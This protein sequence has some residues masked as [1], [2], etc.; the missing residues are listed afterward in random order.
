[1]IG[2]L[3]EANAAAL[4]KWVWSQSEP[5]RLLSES[6]VF[7]INQRKL[8]LFSNSPP[9]LLSFWREAAAVVGLAVRSLPYGWARAGE[10]S[11][12]PKLSGVYSYSDATIFSGCLAAPRSLAPVC[13]TLKEKIPFQPW[14]SACVAETYRDHTSKAGA[15]RGGGEGVLMTAAR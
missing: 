14:H 15:A 11:P 13:S 8:D 10:L 5:G 4:D 3:A 6:L 1:M 2:P 7:L 9:C 12:P